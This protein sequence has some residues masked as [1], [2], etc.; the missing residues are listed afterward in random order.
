LSE[1]K[2]TPD[3]K[4]VAA[5]IQVYILVGLELESTGFDKKAKTKQ[6]MIKYK[7]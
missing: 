3:L 4:S 5:I 2:V 6:N 7:G 1:R